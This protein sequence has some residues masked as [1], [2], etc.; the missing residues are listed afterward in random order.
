MKE[1]IL[2]GHNV[3]FFRHEAAIEELRRRKLIASN[4]ESLESLL[5]V[6]GD[7]CSSAILWSVSNNQLESQKRLSQLV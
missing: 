4:V 7:S 6:E 2:D 5:P 3:L 1:A